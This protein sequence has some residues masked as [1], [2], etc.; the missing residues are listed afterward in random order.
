MPVRATLDSNVLVYAALEPGSAKGVLAATLIRLTT[1]NGV[2]AVQA[3]LEFVAVIRRRAPS[4]TAK[5]VQQADA[6][7]QVFQTAPTTLLIMT[8][9][10]RLVHAHQF[11]VWDAVIWSAA[12]A[13]GATVFLSEDLQD[14][15]TLNSMRVVNPFSRSEAELQALLAH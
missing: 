3:L 4:L 10:L 7:A 2:L 9:A 11:Q 12:R 14:G 1:P 6:W 5:A 13:A 8:D 15:M